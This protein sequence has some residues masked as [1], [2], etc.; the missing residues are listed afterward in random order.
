MAESEEELKSLLR[1]VKEESEKVGLKLNIQRTKTFHKLRQITQLLSLQLFNDSLLPSIWNPCSD[2]QKRAFIICLP[3]YHHPP[4][5]LPLRQRLVSVTYLLVPPPLCKLFPLP[6]I[7]FFTLWP[8]H[9][10]FL[11]LPTHCFLADSMVHPKLSWVHFLGEITAPCTW[12]DWSHI[13][14][15]LSTIYSFNWL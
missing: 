13:C 9:S 7:L 15:N 11:D 12:L 8:S 3:R 14:N 6:G 10:H 5:H 2:L 1:K 4:H